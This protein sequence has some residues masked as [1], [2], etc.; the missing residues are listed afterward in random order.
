MAY[1]WSK[2]FLDRCKRK[3]KKYYKYMLRRTVIRP[4]HIENTN[5]YIPTTWI[6][7]ININWNMKIFCD[8]HI[9]GTFSILSEAAI[10]SDSLASFCDMWPISFCTK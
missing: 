6:H 10:I 2:R 9:S 8:Y 7:K 4:Q 1:R 3:D 5:Q